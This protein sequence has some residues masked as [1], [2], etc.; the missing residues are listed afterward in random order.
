M[1]KEKKKYKY[2]TRALTCPDGTRK[3]IRAKT[4]KELEEKVRAAQAELDKGVNIN[5]STTF[6]ELTQM[7]VDLV[8]RPRLRP[9]SMVTLLTQVN[10]HLMP[11]LG[12]LKVRDIKPL[13]CAQVVSGMSHLSKQTQGNIL[14]ELKSIFNFALENQLISRSPVLPSLKPSGAPPQESVPL[15]PEECGRLLRVTQGRY[16]T[17]WLHTFVL[18]CLFTGLRAAEACGLC[19]D[20]VDFDRNMILVRRQVVKSG[21]GC[22][23][24][25]ELK[26]ASSSRD[27]PA[28]PE[29]MAH[30]RE[31]KSR[32]T[33]ITVL[34]G[35]RGLLKPDRPAGALRKL[36]Q[37]SGVHP[38]LLRHTYAT[39]LVEAGV[40][41]KTV[42]YLLG[43]TTPVMTLRI[44]AH[45]DRKS[46]AFATA[47]QVANI[48]FATEPVAKVLQIANG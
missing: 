43:H 38:H 40:D 6:A 18:L 14:A 17:P 21:K 41:V 22:I 2:F 12:S 35:Q 34:A 20:C 33:S 39:R 42:Q 29:L 10:N 8:K 11:T 31:L 28:P 37:V 36:P 23:L 26:T 30:L 25:S 3:Y 7:W 5:D 13:H 46:R 15:T 45:Y 24:T 9:Q 32:T 1:E 27:I 47:S 16:T 4:K 44:Y 19:W 48:S